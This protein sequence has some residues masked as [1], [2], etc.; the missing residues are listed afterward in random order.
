MHVAILIS[1]LVIGLVGLGFWKK[2]ACYFIITLVTLFIIMTGLQSLGWITWWLNKKS[3]L[4]SA[5]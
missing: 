5:L 1:I 2:Q 4:R 3:R